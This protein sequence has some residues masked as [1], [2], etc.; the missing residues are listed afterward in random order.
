MNFEIGDLIVYTP[1]IDKLAPPLTRSP[2]WGIVIGLIPD[3]IR[4]KFSDSEAIYHVL[5]SA[6]THHPYSL[7]YI[8]QLFKP[9][10]S[11]FKEALESREARQ[12]MLQKTP[13]SVRLPGPA[14]IVQAFITNVRR[15]KTNLSKLTRQ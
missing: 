2:D 7:K 11:E 1:N 9:C 8:K 4:M 14:H 6:I 13:L 10:F 15:H 5:P 3:Y 12:V